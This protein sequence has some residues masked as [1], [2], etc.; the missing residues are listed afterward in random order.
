MR[1]FTFMEKDGGVALG[2]GFGLRDGQNRDEDNGFVFH[3]RCLCNESPCYHD[4]DWHEYAASASEEELGKAKIRRVLEDILRKD[5]G[6]LKRAL[7]VS[8]YG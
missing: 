2:I 6:A 5:E 3:S 4:G 7:E 1:I 8:L